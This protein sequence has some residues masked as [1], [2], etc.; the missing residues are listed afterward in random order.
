MSDPVKSRIA[1]GRH[2]YGRSLSAAI[3]VVLAA[4]LLA[5]CGSVFGD[6]KPEMVSNDPPSTIYGKA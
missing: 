3:G 4:G 6:S 1:P 2:A 5:G